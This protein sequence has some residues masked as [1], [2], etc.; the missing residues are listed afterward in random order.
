M[1]LLL[2][3]QL[4]IFFSNPTTTIQQN[5][6]I[7]SNSDLSALY[8]I[9]NTLTDI[10][11]SSPFFSTWNFKSPDPCSSFAGITCTAVNSGRRRITSLTLGT[12]LSDSRGLAGSL[13]ASLS[14]LTELTQLILFPGVVTGP[15][16]SQVGSLKK[17]RVISLTNNR[18]TGPI[19]TTISSLSNL[20]TLDLSYNQLTGS[21]PPNIK[22]G[23]PKL[24]V[25]V[26]SSNR[27]AGHL[28]ELPTQL[29]HLDLK[30]NGIS[31][32][33][34]VQMPLTLRYFSLS[35]NKMWGPLNGLDSLSELV[36]L[37]LSMNKFSGPIPAS[38]FRPSLSSMFLQRNNLSRG[39]PSLSSPPSY[40]PGSIVDLSHNIL[41]G[42]LS[43]VLIG[44]ESIYLNNNRLM[45]K[46]PEEY[47]VSVNSG[48]TKTLYLQHNYISGFPKPGSATPDSAS[49]CLNYNCMVPPVWLTAC[50][51]SAGG[52]LSRPANQCAAFYNRSSSTG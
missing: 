3:F 32:I 35:I 49:V 8:E 41:T 20:H 7:I 19:P 43:T 45:G 4:L 17:L 21:V 52:Q 1:G 42:E 2:L 22:T 12:G 36:Y 14:N 33:L 29:L 26:L 18:L 37:D 44:A 48:S 15:I 11:S 34:P 51:A 23:L 38:L 30:N 10:P 13:P 31:G 40:G 39:V 27:L 25:L 24:K 46:V 28:P 6:P 16:P 47:V 5:S 50:P 9:K